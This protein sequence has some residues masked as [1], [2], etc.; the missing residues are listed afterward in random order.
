MAISP[1]MYTEPNKLRL[2]ALKLEGFRLGAT[3]L[4]CPRCDF[5]YE[6]DGA[7]DRI[8]WVCDLSLHA[9]TVTPDLLTSSRAAA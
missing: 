4:F 9:I 2:A 6:Y 8:C 1:G 5:Q 7:G 3:V